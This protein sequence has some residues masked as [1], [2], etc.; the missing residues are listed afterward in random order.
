MID[1][2]QRLSGEGIL[3]R[4]HYLICPMK[5]DT[6][7]PYFQETLEYHYGK[8]H[9]TYVVNLNK[10][11]ENRGCGFIVGRDHQNLLW[12]I[13]NN[14][15]QVWNHTFIGIVY[16]PMVVGEPQGKLA[17]DSWNVWLIC[18]VKGTISQTSNT[19]FGSGWDGWFKMLKVTSKSSVPA[20]P[21]TPMT[22]AWN[23]HWPAMFGTCLLHRLS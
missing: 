10:L 22:E 17:L 7:T 15:A 4:F 1:H 6:G 18:R 16:R 11:I 5:W 3:W 9:H 12:R 23:R 13:F 8:H 2:F 19:T 14:A 20:M 21:G